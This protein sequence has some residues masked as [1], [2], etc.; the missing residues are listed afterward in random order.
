MMQ[1]LKVE[2]WSKKITKVIGF[3]AR[4]FIFGS[5]I[6]R[7]LGCGFVMLRK[8]GKVA[9][10]NVVTV[11]YSTEY[12]DD[13]LEMHRGLCGKDD[14]CLLVDDIVAT[15]GTLNAGVRALSEETNIVGS[16]CV[17]KVAPL[18]QQAVDKLKP[19]KILTLF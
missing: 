17:L 13:T 2:G 7:E 5:I 12:S 18:W 8:K 4:G 1:E 16:L 15:G 10:Q 11:H 19:Y 3:D 14:Y 9:G 6:A